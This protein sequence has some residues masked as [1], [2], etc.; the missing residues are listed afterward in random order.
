MVDIETD[1]DN[2]IDTIL[3]YALFFVLYWIVSNKYVW[4]YA[5]CLSSATCPMAYLFKHLVITWRHH[6]RGF[7]GGED[8]GLM[9]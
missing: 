4:I 3:K 8:S 1:G 7:E 5:K 9:D 2:L 6:K